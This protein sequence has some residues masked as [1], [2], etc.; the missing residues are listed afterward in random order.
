MFEV[1]TCLNNIGGRG[2]DAAECDLFSSKPGLYGAGVQELLDSGGRVS[3]FELA[4]KYV[5]FGGYRY[6]GSD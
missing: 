6:N 1:L 3:V 4:K 2:F 5:I